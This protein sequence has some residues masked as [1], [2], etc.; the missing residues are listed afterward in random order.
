[1]Y[2]IYNI[3]IQ[4]EELKKYHDFL[5]KLLQLSLAGGRKMDGVVYDY[6]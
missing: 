5:N 2:N 3:Y 6:G 1:M 4:I